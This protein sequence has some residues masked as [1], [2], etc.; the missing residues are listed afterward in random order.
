MTT[1]DRLEYLRAEIRAERISYGEI[2]ELSDLAEYINPSDTELLE[3]AGVP[4]FGP[5]REA[6]AEAYARH[7]GAVT[8]EFARDDTGNLRPVDFS[9]DGVA[10]PDSGASAPESEV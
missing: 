1:R 4:E 7:S 8:I 5:E 6:Q 3:W 9:S 10:W 2:A